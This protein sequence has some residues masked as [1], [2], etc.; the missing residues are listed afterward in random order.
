MFQQF[1]KQAAKATLLYRGEL[2][3]RSRSVGPPTLDISAAVI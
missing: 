1:Q 2:P 3:R